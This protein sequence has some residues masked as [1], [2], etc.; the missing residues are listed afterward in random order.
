MLI[1]NVE[2]GCE[3]N[4]FL[5]ANFPY[6]FNIKCSI[7]QRKSK[8]LKRSCLTR[9]D[10]YLCTI[11]LMTEISRYR[12]IAVNMFQ[13]FS[14]QSKINLQINQNKRERIIVKFQSLFLKR[15]HVEDTKTFDLKFRG[16]DESLCGT[17][18]TDQFLKSCPAGGN[19]HSCWHDY[20]SRADRIY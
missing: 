7:F 4:F 15:A 20:C 8:V 9:D 17:V 11:M 2:E 6:L 13:I 12:G 5:V 3:L 1:A 18:F 16:W 10:I 19:K 14:R